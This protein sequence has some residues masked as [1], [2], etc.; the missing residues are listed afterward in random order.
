MNKK[1]AAILSAYTGILIGEFHEMHKYI[2][3]IMD[4]PVM[5]HQLGDKEFVAKVKDAA[6]LDFLDINDSITN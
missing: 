1:E 4:G 2:E 3:D 6:Y 5:T